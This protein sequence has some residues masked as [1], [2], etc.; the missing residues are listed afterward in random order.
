MKERIQDMMLLDVSV[1]KTYIPKKHSTGATSGAGTEFNPG[2]Q[3]GSCYSIFSFICNVLYIV[4][5][6][7]SFAIVLSPSP[8]YGFWIPLWYLQESSFISIEI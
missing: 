2:F 3:L 8:I 5:Y 1:S 6:P 4:V 7:F